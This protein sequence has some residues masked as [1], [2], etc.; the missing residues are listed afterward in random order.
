MTFR[1]WIAG[2]RAEIDA[3][4]E[5]FAELIRA[6]MNVSPQPVEIIVPAIDV[7]RPGGSRQALLGARSLFANASTPKASKRWS[8]SASPKAGDRRARSCAVTSERQRRDR[9]PLNGNGAA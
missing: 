1:L 2:T 5:R 6:R 4:F 7:L 9:P 3:E 8:S